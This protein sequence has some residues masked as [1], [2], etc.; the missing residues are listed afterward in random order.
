MDRER[1]T[2]VEHIVSKTEELIAQIDLVFREGEPKYRTPDA[3]EQAVGSV[4]DKISD[5]LTEEQG[6]LR[7]DSEDSAKETEAHVALE[8]TVEYLEHAL[9][10]TNAAL[11]AVGSEDFEDA[12]TRLQDSIHQLNK[13]M[14]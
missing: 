3:W 9:N 13:A 14:G 10:Q 8:E 4:S 11:D 1:R 12:R 6:A 2:E 5:I 7:T